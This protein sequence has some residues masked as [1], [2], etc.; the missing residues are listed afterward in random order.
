MQDL[1]EKLQ[2]VNALL[3]G[4]AENEQA[5][6]L[7]ERVGLTKVNNEACKTCELLDKLRPWM[8]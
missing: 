8:L 1:L 7:R 2:E 4:L 3:A 6:P 5:I